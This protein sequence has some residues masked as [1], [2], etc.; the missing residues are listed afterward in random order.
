M[1][2]KFGL[3]KTRTPYRRLPVK[4]LRGIVEI[5]LGADNFCY[6]NTKNH[7]RVDLTEWMTRFGGKEVELQ[8]RELTQLT[9][10]D[11]GEKLK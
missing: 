10:S 4:V 8:V 7:R 11:K 2:R 3:I 9:G 1:S 5:N 6:I